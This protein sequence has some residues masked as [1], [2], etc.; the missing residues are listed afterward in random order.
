MPDHRGAA[1]RSGCQ[2]R[3]SAACRRQQRQEGGKG[4]DAKAERKNEGN[5]AIGTDAAVLHDLQRAFPIAP[6]AETIGRIP[7]AVLMQGAGDHRLH[8]DD[9]EGAEERARVKR[10]QNERYRGGRKGDE[11]S[12]K[13]ESAHGA[14]EPAVIAVEI[15]IRHGN[16]AQEGNRPCDVIPELAN[17]CHL[18]SRIPNRPAFRGIMRDD[19][20]WRK[21]RCRGR[22]H[23]L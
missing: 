19:G 4:G 11:D 22:P 8:R 1:Q 2:Q 20:N 18:V 14:A 16:A 15:S 12:R 13:R 21:C 6:A 9:E 5:R 7:K 23:T 10:A 17:I 3:D